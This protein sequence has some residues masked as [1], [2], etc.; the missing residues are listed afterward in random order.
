MVDLEVTHPI[1]LQL[2]VEEVAMV[3]AASLTVSVSIESSN[4]STVV[5]LL[6]CRA[7]FGLLQVAFRY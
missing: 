5:Q 7:G 2:R 3:E 6:W 1:L 4:S